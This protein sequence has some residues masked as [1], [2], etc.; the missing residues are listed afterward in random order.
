[1]ETI[2]FKNV[3]FSYPGCEKK[4]LDNITLSLGNS[5]FI[6]LCG[7]SGCGKSTLLRQ[8]KKILFHMVC[9]KAAFNTWGLK[10]LSLITIPVQPK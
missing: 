7:K 3:S 6:V 9:L 1:M 5:E 2:S 10:S 8:I 4:A